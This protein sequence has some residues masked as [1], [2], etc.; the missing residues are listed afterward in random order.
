[1]QYNLY[2]MQKQHKMMIGDKLDECTCVEKV[3][4]NKASQLQ[5]RDDT[6]RKGEG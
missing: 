6:G 4:D 3:Y 1:M 2:E 5:H